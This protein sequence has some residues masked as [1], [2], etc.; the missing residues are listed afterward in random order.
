MKRLYGLQ[1]DKENVILSI[2]EDKAKLTIET[3][4]TVKVRELDLQ[5]DVKSDKSVSL[6][7]IKTMGFSSNYDGGNESEVYE[8][9]GMIGI[10]TESMNSNIVQSIDEMSKKLND[11]DDKINLK[12]DT[13]EFW[14][15]I[16][17]FLEKQQ[18]KVKLNLG[19]KDYQSI[20]DAFKRR[21][22]DPVRELD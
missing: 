13:K 2:N 6:E 5:S 9:N 22:E 16:D 15:F 12:V 18:T 14:D 11:L 3:A 21:D 4:D 17:Y 7:K 8:E 10:K 1:T 20:V 19:G